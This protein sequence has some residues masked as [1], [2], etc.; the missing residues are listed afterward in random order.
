MSS[1]HDPIRRIS[2]A[3][4]A[5]PFSC[6]PARTCWAAPRWRRSPAKHSAGSTQ[7]LSRRAH[8][9]AHA[10]RAEGQAGHLSAHGRRPVADGPVRLQAR[11][12]R[13]V[14]Q[15]PARI[16]P[17]GPAA[18]DDDQRPGP[19][20]DRAVDVPVRALRPIGHVDQRTAAEPQEIGRRPRVHPQHAH[21]GDQSRAG[22]HADAN[23][24]PDHRPAVPRRVG[25]LRPRLAERQPADVRR[26]G[27]QELE[28]R[29]S[30]GDLRPAVVERLPAR[31]A[32]RRQLPH[33]RRSDS[34]HQRSAG[35]ARA[36]C[37]AQASTASTRSTS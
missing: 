24:Q 14:R 27:R 15:G 3:R 36:M 11:H 21:R 16:G 9:A 6:R 18:H 30:A 23:R 17:H 5:P 35:R 25:V 8:A 19:L 2:S 22:H 28:H 12:E 26:D 10:L 31:P 1:R 32:R 20:P 29:T 34:V 37:A 13:L 7:L 4:L 33:G